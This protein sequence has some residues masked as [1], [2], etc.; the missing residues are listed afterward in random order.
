MMKRKKD[1]WS[2][3]KD[4][5][6]SGGK[7]SWKIKAEKSYERIGMELRLKIYIY[8]YIYIYF[9]FFFFEK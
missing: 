6:V 3:N 8:I 4:K 1:I 9:F 7:I 5:N 2:I